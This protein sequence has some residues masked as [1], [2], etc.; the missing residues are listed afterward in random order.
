M[1]LRLQRGRRGNRGNLIGVEVTSKINI[2]QSIV[3][4]VTLVTSIISRACMKEISCIHKI[5]LLGLPPLCKIE[6]TEV[7]EVTG[8][9]QI[10]VFRLPLPFQSYLWLPLPPSLEAFL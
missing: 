2:Y 4:S 10:T 8:G 1:R 3:T 6:V 9:R 5:I 7:T